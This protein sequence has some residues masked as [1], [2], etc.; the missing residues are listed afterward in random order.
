MNYKLSSNKTSNISRFRF[1]ILFP[2]LL[3][4]C[5]GSNSFSFDIIPFITKII[6][7]LIIIVFVVYIWN[8]SVERK[9]KVISNKFM[10]QEKE[11]RYKAF[12]DSLTGLPNRNLF[13]DRLDMAIAHSKRTGS[14]LAIL[15]LDMDDFKNINDS[16]GH[17]RGDEFLRII[18]DRLI[19]SNREIDTVARIGGDEFII[20]IP[21]LSDRNKIYSIIDRIQK[22]ICRLICF[23]SYEITPSM[24]IGVSFYPCYGQDSRQI[25][26]NADLAMYHSKKKK[27]GCYSIFCEH[28]K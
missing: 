11:L 13:E 14:D 27:K 25:I 5:K 3:I 8:W 10:D 15:F 12:H 24:S 18:A 26:E 17:N 9:V 20:L 16:F 7:S 28:M 19:Q 23:D 2:F 22:N 1:F 21:E 6:L 4:S